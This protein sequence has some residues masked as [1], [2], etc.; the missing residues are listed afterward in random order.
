MTESGKTTLARNLAAQFKRNSVGVLVLD[1]LA[2]PRWTCDFVTADPS[3]FL[4]VFWRSR[5]CIAFIDEGSESVGRYDVAMQATFTRGRHWG[6]SCFVIAQKATQLA[7]V[8]REQAS[9]LFL[10]CCAKK[11]GVLLAEDFNEPR[12]EE[13]SNLKRF[14]YLHAVKFGGVSHHKTGVQ[15]DDTLADCNGGWVGDGRMRRGPGEVEG[16][17]VEG[18]AA[19]PADPAEP[20][21]AGSADDPA[22]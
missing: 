13:C 14:E 5:R 6:H 9:H 8:V 16:T 4:D 15:S 11:N 2:D 1:P 18:L 20:G 17:E 22:G 12:L 3:D 10:F 7:P 19:D 21:G